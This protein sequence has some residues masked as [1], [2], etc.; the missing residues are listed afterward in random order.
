LRW[1]ASAPKLGGMAKLR[2]VFEPYNSGAAELVRDRLAL[3]NVAVTGRSDYWPVQFFLRDDQDEIFG[4]LLGSVWAGW[5]FVSSLWVDKPARGKGH[6]TRMMDAA[7]ALARER[8]CES[9]FLDTHS[10]QAR[11][12]YEKRGYEVFGTLDDYPEG[13]QRFFLKKKL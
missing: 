1:C 12:F 10:F 6:A 7:E 4:G 9:V 5:L 3:Y 11:P 8:G 13:H 2:V